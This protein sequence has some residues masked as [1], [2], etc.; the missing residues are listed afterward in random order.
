MCSEAHGGSVKNIPSYR[1]V[2]AKPALTTSP[3]NTPDQSL[4]AILCVK[5]LKRR[6]WASY[7]D[8][9]RRFTLASTKVR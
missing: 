5:M 1:W 7:L 8:L 9:H 3:G 2:T 6:G 4:G